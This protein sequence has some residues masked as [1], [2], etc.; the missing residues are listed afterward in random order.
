[1]SSFKLT[2]LKLMKMAEIFASQ[3]RSDMHR[4]MKKNGKDLKMQ[5]NLK[6]MNAAAEFV[7]DNDNAAP[8]LDQALAK[9]EKLIYDV[10][11]K[12]GATLSDQPDLSNNQICQLF[13]LKSYLGLTKDF[14]SAKAKDGKIDA[15][16]YKIE[17]VFHLKIIHEEVNREAFNEY[18]M[19]H[20]E[21]QSVAMT[22]IT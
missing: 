8:L 5:E 7:I 21:F 19:T 14:F 11:A 10:A 3:T 4:I 2:P 6:A 9:Y 12:V 15:N 16:V 17:M 20:V 1:M 22:I 13:D 18:D